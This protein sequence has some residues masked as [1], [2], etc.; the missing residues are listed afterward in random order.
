MSRIDDLKKQ[1]PHFNLS[2][3][4]YLR[5]VDISKTGKYLPIICKVFDDRYDIQMK[6][7]TEDNLENM[8]E[9]LKDNGVLTKG[10][11]IKEIIIA[12]AF[13]DYFGANNFDLLSDFM[14]F[15]ERNLIENKDILT[16]KSIDD[17]RNAVSLAGL[18]DTM[19]E[20]ETKIHREFEDNTWL[21][22]RPLTFASSA[23]YGASTKWCT[24]HRKEKSYF[25]KYMTNGALFYFINKITGYKFALYRDLI[26][27][28][29]ISFWDSSDNRVDFLEIEVDDYLLPFI[30]T[31][32]KTEKRNKDFCTQEEYEIVKYECDFHN[33]NLNHYEAPGIRLHEELYVPRFDS[34]DIDIEI[35]T[36]TLR[37]QAHN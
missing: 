2:I 4:D 3:L 31:L 8:S 30:K 32:I 10:L 9:R 17:I 27:I 23:K 26:G 25:A 37:A 1:Y 22:L 11:N 29:E 28:P 18:K 12:Y 16:Y 14:D 19:N 36:P 20:S 33:Y 34:D 13:N 15:M 21:V 6:E 24:T 7:M 35:A 5:M